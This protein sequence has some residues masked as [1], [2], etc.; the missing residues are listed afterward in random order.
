MRLAEKRET[1]EDKINNNYSILDEKKLEFASLIAQGTERTPAFRDVF[2]YV[3]NTQI[4]S[5]RS[6]WE[7]TVSKIPFNKLYERMKNIEGW[8]ISGWVQILLWLA[9]GTPGSNGKLM[10]GNQTAEELCQSLIAI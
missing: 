10:F 5:M 6:T 4:K 2:G 7:G 1:I 3:S 9:L 8:T